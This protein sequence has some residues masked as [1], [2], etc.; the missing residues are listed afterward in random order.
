MSMHFCGRANSHVIYPHSCALPLYSC[1]VNQAEKLI[2][3][4][5]THKMYI[6]LICFNSSLHLEALIWHHTLLY[7]TL[8]TKGKEWQADN[9]N[10]FSFHLFGPFPCFI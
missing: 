6:I 9:N 2:T 1:T 10:L 8:H 5:N 4:K 3:H 7:H